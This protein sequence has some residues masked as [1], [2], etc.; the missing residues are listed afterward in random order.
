MSASHSTPIR[1]LLSKLD[2]LHETRLIGADWISSSETFPVYDPATNRVVAAVASFTTAD[3]IWAIESAHTAFQSFRYT[4]EHERSRKLHK[5]AAL[6][7]Q[8]Q[9]AWP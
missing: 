6:I 7:R 8:M 4:S 5:L 2:L 3:F 9:R 1:T